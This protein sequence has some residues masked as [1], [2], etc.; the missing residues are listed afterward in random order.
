MAKT[1]A[2]PAAPAAQNFCSVCGKPVKAGKNC[3]ALCAARLASG[4]TATQIVA[5]KQQLS[6]AVAPAGYVSVAS[7]HKLCVQNFVPVSKMVKAMGG[8][9]AM[10]PVAHPICTPCYTPQGRY[11]HGW[12]G[13]K[14]GLQALLTGNF[15]SAPSVQAPA[16]NNKP[17]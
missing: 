12:L 3:G 7:L 10:Y 14:Q 5:R 9:R 16:T 4:Q 8:D 6:V 11:V 17:K 1:P 15:S 2:T 13:T